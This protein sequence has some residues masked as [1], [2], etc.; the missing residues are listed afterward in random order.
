MT[1]P[2]GLLTLQGD[3][4]KHRQAFA[5]LGEELQQRSAPKFI[6]RRRLHAKSDQSNRH[7]TSARCIDTFRNWQKT[8][9]NDRDDGWAS[10]NRSSRPHPSRKP[11]SANLMPEGGV[12]VQVHAAHTESPQLHLQAPILQLPPKLGLQNK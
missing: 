10:F 12:L 7:R 6:S 8:L 5:A 9:V 4:E 1:K 3:Y 2:F 11:A